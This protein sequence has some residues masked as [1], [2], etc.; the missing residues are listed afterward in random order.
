MKDYYEKSKHLP[1]GKLE[2]PFT[3]IELATEKPFPGHFIAKKSSDKYTG[4]EPNEWTRI[5]NGD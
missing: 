4:S 5:I 1:D 2:I 3:P